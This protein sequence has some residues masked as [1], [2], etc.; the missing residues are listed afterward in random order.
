MASDFRF[1]NSFI[2]F[3]FQGLYMAKKKLG[4]TVLIGFF[5]LAKFFFL[6]F[7]IYIYILELRIKRPIQYLHGEVPRSY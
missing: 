7:L 6:Y 3:T 2:D 4:S 5:D 1:P